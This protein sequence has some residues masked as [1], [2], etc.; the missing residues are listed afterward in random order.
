MRGRKREKASR[1]SSQPA[2]QPAGGKGREEGSR[3]WGQ[4]KAERPH[5]WEPPTRQMERAVD[6]GTRRARPR[7]RKWGEEA[8]EGLEQMRA[9]E[10]GNRAQA[11]ENGNGDESVKEC[12][13]PGVGGILGAHPSRHTRV[14]THSGTR[15]LA[16][17]STPTPTGLA[18][19]FPGWERGVSGGGGPPKGPLPRPQEPKPQ[20]P[21]PSLLPATALALPALGG[22][23]AP[24]LR[25]PH[26]GGCRL[27]LLP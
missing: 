3:G 21:H 12:R 24:R 19:V 4:T 9:A 13:G 27:S 23:G 7:S 26:W 5:D 10:A 8:D 16:A 14:C 20:A 18:S 17:S 15:T 1:S 2:S 6:S 11:A 25:G 22:A